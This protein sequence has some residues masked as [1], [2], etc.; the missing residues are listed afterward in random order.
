MK[1][2]FIIKYIFLFFLFLF[3][4]LLFGNNN[5]DNIWNYGVSHAFRIGELPYRDYNSITTPLYQF[6]MSIGL[7][8]YDSYLT[9]IIEQALLC[10][11]FSYILEKLVGDN[12]WFLLS[13]LLF[14]IFY[15]FF[16]NYNFLVMLL[17]IYLLYLEKE[18]R[19]DSII[20]M[21]LGLLVLT[22]HSVGAIILIFSLLST[23]NIRKSLKRLL[24]SLIPISIFLIYLLFTNTF[25]NFLDLC[26]F[27]LFDFAE[28]N[29]YFS[30]LYTSITILCLIYIVY[31]FIK[32]KDYLN[33]YLIPAFALLIPILDMFHCVYF[34]GFFLIIIFIRNKLTI[35]KTIGFIIIAVTILLNTSFNSTYNSLHFSTEGRMKFMLVDK[36]RYNYIQSVLNKY[37]SYDNVCMLSMNSM[38]F[39]IESNKKITYFDIPLYGNFGYNGL[40]KMKNKIDHMHEVYFFVLDNENRQYINKLNNY[41]RENYKYIENIHDIEIYYKE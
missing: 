34:I 40:E 13:L 21:V 39:D 36:V 5:T 41:V 12:F 15:F 32:K 31:S 35:N 23:K 24:Y 19:S 33:Y 18:K 2:K 1:K 28:S 22:K 38:Y 26:V 20:G 37:N 7:F 14:P 8:I 29:N 4:L 6:I 11:I 27:G 30:Y 9:F 17:F 3:I 16:A 10:T 25:M